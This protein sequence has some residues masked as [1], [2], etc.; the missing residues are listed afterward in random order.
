MH[1]V[2]TL[3]LLSKQNAKLAKFYIALRSSMCSPSFWNYMS[4]VSI[5]MSSSLVQ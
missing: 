2:H 4:F 5:I 1:F 3:V